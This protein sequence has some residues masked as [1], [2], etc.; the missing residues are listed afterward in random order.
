MWGLEPD[1]C[2]E[3]APVDGRVPS[4]VLGLYRP[5]DR[6]RVYTL[7]VIMRICDSTIRRPRV[8]FPTARESLAESEAQREQAIAERIRLEQE[9]AEL[10][11]RLE[12]RDAYS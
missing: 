2:A 9:L 10:R 4:E 6:D 3:I 7:N 11:R 5:I 1:G 12:Q 8:G